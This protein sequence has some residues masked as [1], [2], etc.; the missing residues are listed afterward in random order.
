MW[1]RSMH[2]NYEF[3]LEFLCSLYIVNPCIIFRSWTKSFDRSGTRPLWGVSVVQ[4]W[5][6][7]KGSLK[8]TRWNPAR[9][10][11]NWNAQK[12]FIRLV[13]ETYPRK[14]KN[15]GYYYQCPFSEWIHSSCREIG[16]KIWWEEWLYI[17]RE[18]S[19]HFTHE[20]LSVTTGVPVPCA[21]HERKSVSS[22][23]QHLSPPVTHVC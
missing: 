21:P 20:I 9:P 5:A 23:A 14:W 19:C 17:A 1:E 2:D 8:Y 16:C 12:C 6:P 18:N 11:D 3:K 4:L 15:M 10:P 7:P 22:P 13:A